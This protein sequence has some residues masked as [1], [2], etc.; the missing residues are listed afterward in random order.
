MKIGCVKEIKTHE[1]RVG[2]TPSD[3]KSYVSRGHKVT[4]QQGAGED[5]GF[6]DEEYRMSG[7]VLE[8]DRKKIFD[9]SEMIVKVKEPLPE[10]YN[11]FH[12]DQILYTYLHLAADRVLTDAMM[13]AGI[14]GVAYETIETADGQLPCLQPMSEIAG[15]L[16]VQEGAKFLEKTFGG[17]GVL[18]GGVPGVERGK[19][20]IIGGGVVGTNACKIATGMGADVTILDV[21]ATKLAYLDDIFGS[22]ITTLYSTDANIEKILRESDLIIGAVL[23]AGA[24]APT[25][26]KREH[27]KLMKK[28]AVIVDVAVDQ[29]GCVETIKPTTHDDPVYVIDDIVHYAVAN[30]PGAVALTSTKALTSA[31]LPYGLMIAEMGLE[32]AIRKSAALKQGVNVYN[33]KCVYE[34]VAKTFNIPY[35]PLEDL[36]K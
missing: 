28:G 34:K 26:V 31:T 3:V 2:L 20:G 23:L 24:K 21:S 33:G 22:R 17:R 7:A 4:I 15:R 35:T 25:L 5:A 27:L 10:E 32:N 16:A 9:G 1:Y 6:T 11:L 19:V 29:G 18:L 14:K 36:L 13:K 12:K 30:M 8:A